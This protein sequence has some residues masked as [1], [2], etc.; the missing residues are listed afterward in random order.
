[1]LQAHSDRKSAESDCALSPLSAPRSGGSAV[2]STVVRQK[3][4]VAS[5]ALV[6]LLAT[7]IA[8]TLSTVSYCVGRNTESEL[9]FLE[10][11]RLPTIDEVLVACPIEYALRSGERNEVIFVGDSTCRAGVDPIRFERLS[12]LRAFNLASQ[13]RIGPMGF[14]ITGKAYLSNHPRPR[15]VVLGMSPLAFECSAVEIADKM[16]STMQAR[17][18]ANYG[19]EVPGVVPVRQIASYF[20]QRGSLSAWGAV[21]SAYR[22]RDLDVRDLPVVGGPETTP[23]MTFRSIQQSVLNSRGFW[24]VI[25]D[26]VVRPEIESPGEPVKIQDEWNRSVRL[27]AQTCQD[28]GI[29][30]LIRFSPMPSDLSHVKDFSTI[31]QWS[32]DLQSAYPNV[33]IGSPILLWYD[34]D[35][36]WEHIHLNDRGVAAYMSHLAKEAHDILD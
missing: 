8:T 23:L 9:R 5:T 21:S 1:M 26:H 33:R 2:D 20:I 11:R 29:P 10:P 15:L 35:L 12:G 32:H 3:H 31:E 18:E 27:L 4:R 14:L 7:A 30:L 36:C 25:G 19:P 16:K 28:V 34:P 6:L 22:G 24:P 13:G 17:F